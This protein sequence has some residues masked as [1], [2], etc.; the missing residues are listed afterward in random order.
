MLFQLYNHISVTVTGDFMPDQK[1]I[2]EIICELCRQFY[3]L[4]WA[5]GTGGG[6]CVRNGEKLWVA[7][8]GVQKERV[9][10]E[11][12]FAVDFEGQVIHRPANEKL[13]PSE[14]TSLF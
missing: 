1:T 8:S 6:I 5:T 11:D 10:P 12:L 14:C 4:G 3:A 2:Q 9:Q 7:P 13:K